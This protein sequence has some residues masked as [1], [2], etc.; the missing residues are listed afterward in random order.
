MVQLKPVDAAV[1]QPKPKYGYL[2]EVDPD[3]APLREETDKNFA[4]LWSLPMDEFKTAWLNAPIALPEDAPQPGKDY[5]VSDQQIPVR[6]GAKVGLRFYKP[7]EPVENAMLVL[8]AHGG[9]EPRLSVLPNL[10][11]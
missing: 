5:Q 4:V 9:G 11:S 10:W 1:A 2:S 3:F 8:K 7:M 6:D